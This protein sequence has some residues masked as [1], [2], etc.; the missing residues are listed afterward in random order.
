MSGMYDRYVGEIARRISLLPP[1]A[2]IV[3]MLA[4]C[5]RMFFVLSRPEVRQACDRSWLRSALDSMWVT[6][7]DESGRM[8]VPDEFEIES[9]SDE[10]VLM[11]TDAILMTR[12]A[13]MERVALD[14][15]ILLIAVELANAVD[16]AQDPEGATDRGSLDAFLVDAGS[17]ASTEVSRQLQDLA[18]MEEAEADS[19]RC[20]ILRARSALQDITCG[21]PL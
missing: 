18:Y 15:R 9:V 14:G 6:N 21:L 3:V 16:A 10:L 1:D 4:A 13:L 2:S 11:A 17:C 19:R 20:T 5:E 12:D 7:A 8:S